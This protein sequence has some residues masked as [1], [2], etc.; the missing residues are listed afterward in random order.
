M[1]A[2]SL[3]QP[4][5]TLMAIGAKT[6]ET[7]SWSTRYRGPLA[8][9]SAKRFAQDQ[10]ALCMEPP[11]STALTDAGIRKL[12]D[13]PLGA[14]L[15]VV[16]LYDVVPTQ[17]TLFEEPG[18]WPPYP[19]VAFGNYG[20]GRFAWKTRGL[21]RVREPIP[22]KGRQGLFEIPDDVVLPHLEAA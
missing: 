8:I 2:L 13:L 14:I 7:R 15:C 6:A 10:R 4:W 1:K 3:W 20:V 19:E 9:L 18:K 17:G 22:Y 12:R 16:D 21:R 11:F 5:A